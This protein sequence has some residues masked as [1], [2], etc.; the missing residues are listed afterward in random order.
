MQLK[1]GLGAFYPDRV[2]SAA[3]GPAWDFHYVTYLY[4]QP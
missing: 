3:P 1:P 4:K 2:S